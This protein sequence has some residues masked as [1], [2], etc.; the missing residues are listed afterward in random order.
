MEGALG[1]AYSPLNRVL[2]QPQNSVTLAV[3]HPDPQQFLQ[4][5]H[6]YSLD[7]LSGGAFLPQSCV[8]DSAAPS[9]A[10]RSWG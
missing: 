7:M 1:K 5:T 2:S 9:P 8:N 4:Q 3:N 10:N 6:F